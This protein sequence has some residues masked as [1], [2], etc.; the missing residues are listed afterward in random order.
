MLTETGPFEEFPCRL[1]REA[2]YTLYTFDGS[3]HAVNYRGSRA[4]LDGEV[5]DVELLPA[6]YQDEDGDIPEAFEGVIHTAYDIA[7]IFDSEEDEE[8]EEVVAST[9]EEARLSCQESC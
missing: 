8:E 9:P 5:Q 7:F 6:H 1:V 3:P 2:G 4:D